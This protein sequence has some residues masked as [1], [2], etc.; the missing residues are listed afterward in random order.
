M[1]PTV[2]LVGGIPGGPELLVVL[3]MFIMMILV[4]LAVVVL[5]VV[6]GVR[7]LGGSDETEELEARVEELE[8]ELDR[9][10]SDEGG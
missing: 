9:E 5:A 6:F 7:F 3:L 10:R 8:Q 1:A 2:V 4:P